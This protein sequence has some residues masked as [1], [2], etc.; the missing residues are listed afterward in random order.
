MGVKSKKLKKKSIETII[1]KY[2]DK[3]QNYV[4]KV[5]KN[6]EFIEVEGL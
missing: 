4:S 6:V 5:P 3:L 2:T 1:I